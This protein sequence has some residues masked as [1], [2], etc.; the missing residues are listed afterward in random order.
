MKFKYIFFIFLCFILMISLTSISAMELSDDNNN[1]STNSYDE[2]L[3]ISNTDLKDNENINDNLKENVDDESNPQISSTNNPSPRIE[4]EN[5]IAD[6]INVSFPEKVYQ[7]SSENITIIL[8]D[9]AS[10]YIKVTIDDIAIYNETITEKTINVPITL[11]VKKLPFIVVNRNI[12]YTSYK[13]DVYYNDIALNINHTLKIMKFNHTY[14]YYPAIPEE[15]LKDD[16][17]TYQSISLIFPSSANGTVDI[18]LDD[19][20]IETLVTYQYTF[21]NISKFNNLSLGEHK[22]RVIYSGDDYYQSSDRN[23]SYNIVDVLANIPNNIILD[24]DDCI[25]LK[26]LNH[27]YGYVSVYFDGTRVIY[28]RLDNHHEFLESLFD[29]VKCGEHTIRVEYNDT[30]FNYVKEKL[31]NIT[32]TIDSIGTS[33][34]YRDDNVFT[35]IVPYDFKRN[36]IKITIDGEPYNFNFDNDGWIDINISRL[37]AGNHTV[38][39]NY[40]GDSKYGDC[41]YI[42]NITVDYSIK[43]PYIIN[44]NDGDNVTVTLP[45]DAIGNLEVYI[46]NILHESV[47]VHEGFALIYLNNLTCGRHNITA[48]YTSSDYDVIGVDSSIYC[49][50]KI[51]QPF[52]FKCGE[53]K[54]LTILFSNQ[55][56][57]IVRFKINN[58]TYEIPCENGKASVSLKNLSIGEYDVEIVLECGDENVTAYTYFEIIENTER[59]IGASNIQM[60]YTA[61]KIYQLKVYDKFG[62]I[63]KSGYIQISIGKNKYKVNISKTGITKFKIP[64]IKPGK[65][66]VTIKYNKVSIKKTLK[67]KSILKANNINFNRKRKLQIRV[68]LSKVN[69]NYLKG[70]IIKI[71]VLGKTYNVKTNSKGIAK[72]NIN[73]KLTNK[74]KKGQKITYK[75][76]YLKDQKKATI[77]VIK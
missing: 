10:G 30:D 7:N 50:F 64:N 44:F 42:Q 41:I 53:D 75:A 66:S 5:E 26:T 4:D 13:V 60:L 45:V 23:F 51:I 46:D 15:I 65:Y 14:D 16:N 36:L 38:V 25:Y 56:I 67:I 31:V 74:L 39:L 49:D 47:P 29:Y 9:E 63:S 52:Y 18:Y 35:I 20:F 17:Q 71:K 12:D 54:N 33:F 21:L 76:I 24:H 58:Y 6:N 22:I 32:Y 48:N 72:L 70:K 43:V 34:T 27:I 2:S 62:K 8:P 73:K 59:I 3:S 68:S 19:E 37:S 61:N 40:T 11:P 28:K 1:L 57:G 69:G 55:T 77:K